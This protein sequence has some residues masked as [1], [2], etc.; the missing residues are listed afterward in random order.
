MTKPLIYL[1]IFC[2]IFTYAGF[3]KNPVNN[4]VIESHNVQLYNPSGNIEILSD[5]DFVSLNLTG[6]GTKDDPY[7]IENLSIST[8]DLHGIRVENVTKSFKITNCVISA[9]FTVIRIFN[10]SSEMIII[11]NN[12]C[13]GTSSHSVGIFVAD[14]PHIRLVSNTCRNAY[15]GIDLNDSPYSLIKSNIL[16]E[17]LIGIRVENNASYSKFIQNQCKNNYDGFHIAN[18][19]NALF[20]NNLIYNNHNGF[21]LTS[22]NREFGSKHCLI[23]NNLF[24]N[25]AGYAII[26]TAFLDQDFTQNN[27]IY[28]NSFINNKQN[29]GSQSKDNGINKWYNES[30]KA[31]NYWTNWLGFGPY[32]IDGDGGSQDLYPLEHPLH[33]THTTIPLIFVGR[34]W[35]IIGLAVFIPIIFVSLIW[36]YLRK[37]RKLKS[38]L[39][40]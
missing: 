22:T 39:F 13:I 14:A 28:Q 23:T 3:E 19:E 5:N 30:L 8:Y 12:T 33:K 35:L 32:K 31:G 9:S 18:T 29:Q 21:F 4:I 17:N 15:S 2:F 37:K 36:I 40:H 24:E 10:C 6:S 11:S 27:E 7:L 25:N 16:E 20:L 38:K 34:L 1:L 26:L